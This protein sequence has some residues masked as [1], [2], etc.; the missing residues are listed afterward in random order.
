MTQS[1]S[2]GVVSFDLGTGD[3]QLG[4]VGLDAVEAPAV[5]NL[6]AAAIAICHILGDCSDSMRNVIREVGAMMEATVQSCKGSDEV[7]SNTVIRI[8]T[9]EGDEGVKDHTEGYQKVLDVKSIAR[10]IRTGGSTPLRKAH[11][12]ALETGLAYGRYL[13]ENDFSSTYEAVFISD[14]GDTDGGPTMADI[15]AKANEMK[16]AKVGNRKVFLSV[17]VIVIG[18]CTGSNSADALARHCKGTN[19]RFID[20]GDATPETIRQI[21]NAISSSIVEASQSA[22]VG[23][24]SKGVMDLNADPTL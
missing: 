22:S 11:M 6:D 5:D 13:A 14:G 8:S 9:F 19:A 24:P 21:G 20:A 4:G 15:L 23:A 18:I 10:G 17:H 12:H 3:F 16:T 7:A 2:V 1:R